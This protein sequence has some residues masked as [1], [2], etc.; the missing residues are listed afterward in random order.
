MSE[1]RVTVLPSLMII[2][3]QTFYQNFFLDN[4]PCDYKQTGLPVLSS[5]FG[6][7]F[8]CVVLFW[9]YLPFLDNFMHFCNKLY[10][11]WLKVIDSAWPGQN[12]CRSEKGY[13]QIFH[14]YIKCR[15]K[16]V[17]FCH[18]IVSLIIPEILSACGGRKLWISDWNS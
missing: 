1:L 9:E 17:K 4:H 6:S 5:L 18:K 16:T 15:T 3:G 2:Q 13:Q 11:L 10:F 8:D 12:I 14:I 7:F